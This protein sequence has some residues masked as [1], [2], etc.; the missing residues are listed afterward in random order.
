MFLVQIN[1]QKKQSMLI[2]D[3]RTQALNQQTELKS[4]KAQED[5]EVPVVP[6]EQEFTMSDADDTMH[7]DDM[8]FSVQYIET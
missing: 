4:Q 3:L 1:N 8:M 2:D 6:V 5:E 7:D